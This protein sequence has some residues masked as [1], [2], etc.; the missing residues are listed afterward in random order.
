MPNNRQQRTQNERLT[1]L[2]KIAEWQGLKALVLDR[3]ASYWPAARLVEIW[4]SFAG[5]APFDDLKPVKKFANRKAAVTRIWGAVTRLSPDVA[6]QAAT[7]APVAAKSK[8]SPTK[9][10]ETR[11]SAPGGEGI[12]DQ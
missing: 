3:V 4:N 1:V 8:K 5:V 7:V 6:P 12:R 10:Q 2:P 11:R 9:G